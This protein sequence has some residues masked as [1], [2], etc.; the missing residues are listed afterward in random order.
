V[1]AQ[2]AQAGALERVVIALAER[3][4][5]QRQPGPPGEQEI[6]IAGEPLASAQAGNRGGR[7]RVREIERWRASTVWYPLLFPKQSA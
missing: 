4:A 3:V 5:I 7:I 6:V 2:P 1:K